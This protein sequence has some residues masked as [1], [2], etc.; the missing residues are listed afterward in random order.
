MACWTHICRNVMFYSKECFVTRDSIFPRNGLGSS[1]A[2]GIS[3]DLRIWVY[4]VVTGTQFNVTLGMFTTTSISQPV[5]V[6]SSLNQL[7]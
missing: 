4:T 5:R 7:I 6:Y 2:H 3:I 1:I